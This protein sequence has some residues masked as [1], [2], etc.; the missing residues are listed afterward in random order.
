MR[1][2]WIVRGFAAVAAGKVT[3]QLLVEELLGRAE[4]SSPGNGTR[5]EAR[6]RS[7]GVCDGGDAFLE[8]PGCYITVL[9]S[10]PTSAGLAPGDSPTCLFQSRRPCSGHT[11]GPHGFVPQA[12]TICQVAT[13]S[14]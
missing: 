12:V 6:K 14:G 11:P 1:E 10:G 3:R 2:V 13:K 5:Q 7:A 8:D 4:Q 9:C